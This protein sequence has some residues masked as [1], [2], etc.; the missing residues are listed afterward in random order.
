VAGVPAIVVPRSAERLVFGALLAFLL[1]L[2]G[3]IAIIG[4]LLPH[5][6]QCGDGGVFGGPPTAAAAAI[7]ATL[8]PIFVAAG[9][10]YGVP[11]S[12]LAA[13]NKVETDFGRNLNVSS[14]GAIGWMQFMPDTWER[15]GVDGDRDGHKDP[16]NPT[17]AI[18]A[19]ANYLAASGA[20]RDLRGAIFAYNHAAW[21]VQE[22]LSLARSYVC[23]VTPPRRLE[24]APRV[25]RLRPA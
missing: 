22:V 19:A 18:A 2:V 14:A 8:M 17:D 15:Y 21:Y 10:R 13:I 3:L 7:P 12:V 6:R 23:R 16:Y 1:A 4:S 25:W 5:Q 11:W 24:R 9:Q 20:Q